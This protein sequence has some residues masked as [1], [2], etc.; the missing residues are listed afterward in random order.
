M[1]NE[2]AKCRSKK[3]KSS[4]LSLFKRKS[5]SKGKAENE[6]SR[7]SSSAATLLPENC[8]Q[9]PHFRWKFDLTQDYTLFD[10]LLNDHVLKQAMHPYEVYFVQIR[11]DAMVQ[12]LPR[13][14]D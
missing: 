10:P 8:E 13:L 6:E 12:D 1:D 5:K 11:S 2:L 4:P 7:A 14:Y 3:G 9:T